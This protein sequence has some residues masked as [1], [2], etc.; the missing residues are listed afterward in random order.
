MKAHASF[1]VPFA[2]WRQE[3]V[4]I[5]QLAVIFMFAAVI[6]AMGKSW[7]QQQG[8]AGTKVSSARVFWPD[9]QLAIFPKPV[10]K[11]A[12]EETTMVSEAPVTIQVQEVLAKPVF[13]QTRG[14][15]QTQPRYVQQLKYQ[16]F[17]VKGF[18][19]SSGPGGYQ[20]HKVSQ[21]VQ[22]VNLKQDQ[23]YEAYMAWVRKTLKEYQQGS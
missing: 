23:S 21:K 16:P 1:Q 6:G 22:T 4:F 3:L 17:R 9:N 14:R 19:K 15:L 12:K 5:G 13:V 8:L 7:L 10:P 11:S 20:K 18:K 2:G